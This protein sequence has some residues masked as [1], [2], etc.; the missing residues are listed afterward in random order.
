MIRTSK[1]Y[2]YSYIAQPRWHGNN[3]QLHLERRKALFSNTSFMLW[4]GAKGNKQT[5]IKHCRVIDIFE[6][7]VVKLRDR[8]VFGY[9]NGIYENYKSTNADPF[10]HPNRGPNIGPALGQKGARINDVRGDWK[11]KKSHT[12][13]GNLII[14]LRRS[15]L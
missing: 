13:H 5:T 3:I 1:S 12:E 11:T 10:Y 8:T 15:Y 6:Q 2:Y 14:F 7:D 4:L 9:F